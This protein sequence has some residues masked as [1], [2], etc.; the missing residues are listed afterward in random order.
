MHLNDVGVNLL[1]NRVGLAV[2]MGFLLSLFLFLLLGSFS[3]NKK[4]IDLHVNSTV[5]CLLGERDLD[6]SISSH[7]WFI[8]YDGASGPK[9]RDCYNINRS[10]M[11]H[12]PAKD[13]YMI[14]LVAIN[15]FK[16]CINNP[17]VYAIIYIYIGRKKLASILQLSS[18]DLS[19][20]ETLNYIYS[21][22]YLFYTQSINM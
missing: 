3:Y 14:K 7:N 12:I 18:R 1:W 9:G 16:Y 2:W 15:L 22:S 20:N 11:T 5:F 10:R 21:K 8:T 6:F 13:Y 4:Y 17:N 19:N